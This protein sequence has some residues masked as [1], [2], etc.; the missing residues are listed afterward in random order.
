M[1]TLTKCY[2]ELEL[3]ARGGG[4]GERASSFFSPPLPMFPQSSTG[5]ERGS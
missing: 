5:G 2:S 1:A 4:G 3:V